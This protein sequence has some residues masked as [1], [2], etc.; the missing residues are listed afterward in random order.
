V[1][2]DSV[3]ELAAALGIVVPTAKTHLHRVFTKTGAKRR[4]DLVKLVAG[5]ASPL[6]N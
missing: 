3:E 5:Y 6:V 2:L 1:Q 4:A